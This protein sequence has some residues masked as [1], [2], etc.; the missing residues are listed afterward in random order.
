MSSNAPEPSRL[1]VSGHQTVYRPTTPPRVQAAIDQWG[2]RIA[3]VGLALYLAASI[4]DGDWGFLHVVATVGLVCSVASTFYAH[5]EKRRRPRPT[6]PIVV[7]DDLLRELRSVPPCSSDQ[8]AAAVK[9]IRDRTNLG[10][11]DAARLERLVREERAAD[12]R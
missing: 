7:P 10:L 11:T 4:V 3:A 1:T 8:R 9:L 5:R 2:L 6:G 12:L